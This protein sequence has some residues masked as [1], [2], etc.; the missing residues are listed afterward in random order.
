MDYLCAVGLRLFKVASTK[1]IERGPIEYRRDRG[2]TVSQTKQLAWSNT[3]RHVGH[4]KARWQVHQR[5]GEMHSP[6]R[7]SP[8]AHGGGP[9]VGRSPRI[10]ISSAK[11]FDKRLS[12]YTLSLERVD[13]RVCSHHQVIVFRPGKCVGIGVPVRF[14]HVRSRSRPRHSYGG[15]RCHHSLVQPSLLAQAIT[16]ATPLGLN[17]GGRT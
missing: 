16:V 13:D 17:P 14:P 3:N 8:S 7:S 9:H 11:T 1:S 15:L 10:E 6:L 2:S 4:C 12:R 5:K